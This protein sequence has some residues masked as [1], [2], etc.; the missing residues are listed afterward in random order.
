MK[1]P[2]RELSAFLS[3]ARMARCG[4]TSGL[5][6][7]GSNLWNGW[8][9]IGP[10]TFPVGAQ[11]SVIHPQSAEGAVSLYVIGS[12]GQV[13]SNFGLPPP[14]RP[15]GAGGSLLGR[16]PFRW[17]PRVRVV[18]PRSVE[19]AVSLYV[20]GADG[21]VWS[22]FWPATFGS[23]Q[24]NGWFSIGQNNVPMGPPLSVIHPRSDEGAVSLYIVGTDGQ[25][26]SNFW[27][28][29]PGS[30]QFGGWFPIGPNT[31]PQGRSISVIHPRSDEGAVSLYIIGLDG[32]VW[33]N[34][35]PS[36][37]GS[38]Q[39]SGWFPVGNNNFPI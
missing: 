12:D 35:W 39:W 22:N 23:T 32:K 24:W 4:R 13:W 6:A 31:F 8:F 2:T 16:T 7:P 29:G 3:S 30:N 18:H 38:I 9:P 37:A 5:P 25:V 10:N 27:P 34:F 11:V 26:W 21:Q 17:D 20:V 15:S 14:D 36:A 33:S 1:D 19:G 28:A